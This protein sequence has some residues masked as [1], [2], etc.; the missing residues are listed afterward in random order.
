MKRIFPAFKLRP[1][2][3]SSATID[4]SEI[5]EA[6]IPQEFLLSLPPLGSLANQRAVSRD[7]TLWR[8]K[9]WSGKFASI[10]FFLFYCE[11]MLSLEVLWLCTVRDSEAFK[12]NLSVGCSRNCHRVIILNRRNMFAFRHTYSLIDS[13]TRDLSERPRW[14][15][16]LSSLLLMHLQFKITIFGIGK[17]LNGWALC[18]TATPVPFVL[19]L[20]QSRLYIDAKT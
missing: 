4:K 15:P 5:G 3:N 20:G 1:Q 9:F 13:W 19:T 12:F 7:V 8:C 14:S 18:F 10:S 6:A 16:S 11:G 17:I 2:N